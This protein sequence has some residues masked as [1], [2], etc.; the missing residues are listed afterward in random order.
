MKEKEAK[1]EEKKRKGGTERKESIRMGVIKN[2]RRRNAQT[3]KLTI[4]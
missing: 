4:R 1:R 2:E 3:S